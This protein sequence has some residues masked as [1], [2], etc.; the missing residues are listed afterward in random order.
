MPTQNSQPTSQSQ[1]NQLQKIRPPS[2]DQ[3]AHRSE[4]GQTYFYGT[5]QRTQQP[6]Y[7]LSYRWRS[8]HPPI[9][10]GFLPIKL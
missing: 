2:N 6:K 1:R 8:S 5:H 9:I 4:A 3:F 7:N 10:Y